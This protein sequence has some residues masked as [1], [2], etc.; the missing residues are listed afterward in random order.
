VDATRIGLTQV[1]HQALFGYPL[2]AGHSV[3]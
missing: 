2:Q 3:T 1:P